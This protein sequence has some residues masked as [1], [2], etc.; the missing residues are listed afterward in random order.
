MADLIQFKPKDDYSEHISYKEVNGERIPVVA[1][2]AMSEDQWQKYC[3]DHGIEPF[4][5]MTISLES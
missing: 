2:D 3:R 5:R 1:I 4:K